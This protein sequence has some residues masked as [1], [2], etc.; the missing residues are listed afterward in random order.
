[1]IES[2]RAQVPPSLLFGRG[3]DPCAPGPWSGPSPGRIRPLAPAARA[4]ESESF[5]LRTPLDVAGLAGDLAQPG[6]GLVRAKG[7]LRDADGSLKTLHVVG[8]RFE[9]SASAHR[10][11]RHRAR[12]HRPFRPPRSRRHRAGNRARDARR[13]NASGRA[14]GESLATARERGDDLQLDRRERL[15]AADEQRPVGVERLRL[16]DAIARAMAAASSYQSSAIP[17][18]STS[19][20]GMSGRRRSSTMCDCT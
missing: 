5:A 19:V 13:R 2:V 15:D 4:Y 18:I 7:V 1:V 17:S 11:S 10:R 12:M 16:G 6:C 14:N 8:A 20:A 3:H 9:V